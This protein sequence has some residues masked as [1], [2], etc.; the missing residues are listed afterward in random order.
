MK[1]QSGSEGETRAEGRGDETGAEGKKSA[2]SEGIRTLKADI[3]GLIDKM[4][5]NENIRVIDGARE[6]SG[7]DSVILFDTGRQT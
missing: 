3:Q 4:G 6:Y 5:L 1:K 2:E 7:M